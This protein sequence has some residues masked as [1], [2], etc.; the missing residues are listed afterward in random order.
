[1]VLKALEEEAKCWASSL[2]RLWTHDV[3]TNS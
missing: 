2:L 1:M 3:L